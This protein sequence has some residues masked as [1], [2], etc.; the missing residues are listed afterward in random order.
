VWLSL[1]LFVTI[2]TVAIIQHSRP[3]AL[4]FYHRS[5][6]P[7]R[8][9]L[10]HLTAHEGGLWFDWAYHDIS[11]PSTQERWS[12]MMRDQ[13]RWWGGY[14][15]DGMVLGFYAD[16]GRLGTRQTVL[17]VRIPYYFVALSS[18]A[19]PAHALSRRLRVRGRRKLGLCLLCG[20]DLRASLHRCPECGATTA[21]GRPEGVTGSR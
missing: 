6:V 5:Y 7:G 12:R 10:I 9:R 11:N 21:H 15:A 16:S 17:L 19:F 20:Y 3:F 13:P 4:G 14:V 18:I 1:V 2:T 8:H